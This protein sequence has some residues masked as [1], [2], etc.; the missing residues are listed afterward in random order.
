MSTNELMKY[1]AAKLNK[2]QGKV[3]EKLAGQSKLKQVTLYY[4]KMTW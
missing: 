1:P 4:S 2:P 3:L